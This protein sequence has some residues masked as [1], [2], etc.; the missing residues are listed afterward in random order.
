MASV[1]V[2]IDVDVV[3]VQAPIL[4]QRGLNPG[5]QGGTIDPVDADAH[6]GRRE[7]E[8]VRLGGGFRHGLNRFG[9]TA[10]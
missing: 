9:S 2:V 1:V 3:D 4:A 10:A 7:R 8:R 6:Q 5:E